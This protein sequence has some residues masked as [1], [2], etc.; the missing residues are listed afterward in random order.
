[1]PDIPRG[2]GDT[3]VSK[4]AS[5]GA[6]PQEA[7]GLTGGQ[8]WLQ[9]IARKIPTKERNMARRSEYGKGGCSRLGGGQW[10]LSRGGLVELKSER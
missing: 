5:Y 4:A 3:T 10:K 7:H 6:C 1:M 9:T 8:K 2:A